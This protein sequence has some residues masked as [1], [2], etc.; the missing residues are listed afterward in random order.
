MNGVFFQSF[1]KC[2]LK[3]FSLSKLTK[4]YK[5]LKYQFDFTHLIVEWLKSI[6]KNLSLE[7]PT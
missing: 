3:F 6:L 2:D 7:A 1:F 5:L 4:L